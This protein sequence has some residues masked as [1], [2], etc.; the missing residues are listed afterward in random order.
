ML[1][2][3]R[4][5]TSSSTQSSAANQIPTLHN[6]SSPRT[7]EDG[8]YPRGQSR[9]RSAQAKLHRSANRYSSP[10]DVMFDDMFVPNGNGVPP[11]H[12]PST[13]VFTK[14]RSENT[15]QKELN[16]LMAIEMRNLSDRC[17][18]NYSQ[19]EM[20]KKE[21]RKLYEEIDSLKMQQQR[22][23]MIISRIFQVFFQSDLK[24]KRKF[25]PTLEQVGQM[26]EN[27]SSG[28]L[29]TNKSGVSAAVR[30]VPNSPTANS[31]PGVMI[32]EISNDECLASATSGWWIPKNIRANNKTGTSQVGAIS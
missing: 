25:G 28:F 6:T 4:K 7:E 16:E 18:Y 13:R 21:N 27:S 12:D 1:G 20:L 23:E 8:F 30:H 15:S 29:Q 17:E 2:I 11:K 14:P 3:R 22:H 10:D 31:P 5:N 9:D 24:R 32:K 19:V 26:L